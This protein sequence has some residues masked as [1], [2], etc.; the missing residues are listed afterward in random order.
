[1]NIFTEIKNKISSRVLKWTET[2]SD[3][4]RPQDDVPEETIRRHL[5]ADYQRL[6]H[7]RSILINYIRRLENIYEEAK[8]G[9]FRIAT[10]KKGTKNR[11]KADL[12]LVAYNTIRNHLDA[13]NQ[14]KKALGMDDQNDEQEP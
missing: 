11:I 1:M 9:M 14:L 7:E 2:P 8:M 13:Q 10:V 3:H 6:T 4:K 5:Y 12:Q